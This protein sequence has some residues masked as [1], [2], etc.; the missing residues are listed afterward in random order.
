MILS[1]KD[2]KSKQDVKRSRNCK[3]KFCECLENHAKRIVNFIKKKQDLFTNVQQE[4]YKNA[5]SLLIFCR[6]V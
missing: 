1:F 5:K 3:E 6:K 2:T 4:L